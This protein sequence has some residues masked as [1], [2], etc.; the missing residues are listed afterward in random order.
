ME[1]CGRLELWIKV[2][3]RTLITTWTTHTQIFYWVTVIPNVVFTNNKEPRNRYFS[4]LN[5]LSFVPIN[6]SCGFS[7]N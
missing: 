5:E 2:T 1:D 7:L 4:T 6:S 3:K